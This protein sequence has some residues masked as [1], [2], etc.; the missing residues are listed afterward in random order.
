MWKRPAESPQTEMITI[1]AVMVNVAFKAAKRFAQL[2][3]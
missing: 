2:M 1:D 3:E